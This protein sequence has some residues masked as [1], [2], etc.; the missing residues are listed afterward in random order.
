MHVIWELSAWK[1]IRIVDD[2]EYVKNV[3]KIFIDKCVIGFVK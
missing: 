2:V 3:E 1:L